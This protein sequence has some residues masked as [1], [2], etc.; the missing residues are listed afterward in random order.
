MRTLQLLRLATRLAL[1]A[2]LG[3]MADATTPLSAEGVSLLASFVI[4]PPRAN[5]HRRDL[6]HRKF[7]SN[8]LH[9]VA[10]TR[11][12]LQLVNARGLTL[13]C[14]HYIPTSPESNSGSPPA[15]P[16]VVYLHGNGSCRVEAE[17][18]FDHTL[19]YGMSVFAFDF[20]G[21]GKSGGEYI[22]LGVFEKFDVQTVV[23]YLTSCSHVSSIALWG[24]SM[25]AATATM[26][27]G[28]V[29]PR[30]SGPRVPS[31]GT[32]EKSPRTLR[33]SLTRGRSKGGSGPSSSG[34]IG[35][36][37]RMR[38]ETA[39]SPSISASS[40]LALNY[41]SDID[42]K[43]G[44]ARIK[45]L[46][47]DSAFASFD[48]LASAMV[49]TMPLP[50]AVPR[51][52]IL[53]VGVRAVRKA[54]RDK[55]GFDVND[56]DPLSACKLIDPS[57]PTLMLQ[58]TKDEIVHLA[59]AQ[60]LL[61]AQSG[62]DVELVTMEGIDHD[63][64]RPSFAIE[65]AFILL[66][67][68]I[69]D[70]LGK[71]SIRY[72]NAIKVRGNDCMVQGRYSDAVYLYSDALE[73][74]LA[75]ERIASGAKWDVSSASALARSLPL[76][77]MGRD[78]A[79]G[80]TKSK[81]I[82]PFSSADANNS[83]SH[84]WPESEDD[85]LPRPLS[86][87]EKLVKHNPFP[88]R[89]MSSR[90]G[91]AF[92]GVTRK[93]T[94]PLVDSHLNVGDSSPGGEG[95]SAV[96]L[97]GHPLGTR[98]AN[99]GTVSKDRLTDDFGSGGFGGRRRRPR[100]SLTHRG[101]SRSGGS[102]DGASQRECG[103][104]SFSGGSSSHPSAL[105]NDASLS[106]GTIA[107]EE[108]LLR[109]HGVTGERKE[110][111]L[112]LFCNRSLAKLKLKQCSSA[113]ADAEFALNIDKSWLRGYQRRAAALKTSGRIEEARLCVVA[114]LTLAPGNAALLTME[115]EFEDEALAAALQ[116]SMNDQ[117][118]PGKPSS[119]NESEGGHPPSS[120]ANGPEQGLSRKPSPTA[121]VRM[122]SA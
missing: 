117:Q 19:A 18:L 118:K 115:A 93:L 31:L 59:H 61:D 13:E 17:L 47:L 43:R 80:A 99:A 22:S 91:E 37:A 69:F 94:R 45:A 21:S 88:K 24:H 2:V 106:H 12:D 44:S 101:T 70:D 107:R 76:E 10:V 96:S 1:V 109:T 5:Y 34:G 60:M 36:H 30:A 40:S 50:A 4:R 29:D 42:D 54:V 73:A 120:F 8:T 58:G 28:F 111:A 20:S 116:A 56:I 53:S 33:P 46:V 89:R 16:V 86:S 92:A 57:L 55:A 84:I 112:A 82:A 102:T 32:G 90:F 67:R 7:Q 48:K 68:A 114:G 113:L 104:G 3:T 100:L 39:V 121:N 49:Q 110:L 62:R 78:G 25:G 11:T 26:Y 81:D 52:L 65:R 71:M 97:S 6:G 9:P 63:A 87:G 23:K 95:E 64:Q 98:L 122:T 66:Q 14:S 77:S 74:L 15:M 105:S 108:E 72:L 79:S 51:R 75:Q 83:A 119:K 103:R 41:P 27:A 85:C 38:S 35:G